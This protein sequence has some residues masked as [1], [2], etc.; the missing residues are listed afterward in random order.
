MDYEDNLGY[1]VN[2]A[3]RLTKWDL[4]NA[5]ASV[6]ITSAQW[7]LIRDIFINEE[8]C[9]S[10]DERIQQLT[11]AAIAERLHADRP[12]VSC[13][14]EKL[15]NQGWTYRI[16]NPKDGRSQVILLTDKA[17]E[18]MPQLG[19]LSENTLEKA[20]KGFDDNEVLL[21]KQ[22]LGRMIENLKPKKV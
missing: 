8:N 4:N 13:M 2:K 21:L 18:L 16:S 14:I 20:I 5:L 7:G 19:I 3:A 10:E 22:Y 1:L 6:G 9:H 11:A 17:K 12:T 15:V